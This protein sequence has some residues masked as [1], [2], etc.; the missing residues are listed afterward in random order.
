MATSKRKPLKR[1][2]HSMPAFVRTALNDEGLMDAYTAR[3]AYWISPG[4]VDGWL[5]RQLSDVCS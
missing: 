2:R 5:S 3:P 4:F 1:A